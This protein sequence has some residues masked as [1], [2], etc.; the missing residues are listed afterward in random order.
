MTN[1]EKTIVIQL[2]EGLNSA[3]E[4]TSSTYNWLLHMRDK[5]KDLVP[6]EYFTTIPYSHEE[7]ERKGSE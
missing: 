4:E 6:K 3:V 1:E 7:T 5:M 2:Y